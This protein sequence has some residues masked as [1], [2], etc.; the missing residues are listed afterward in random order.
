M[1]VDRSNGATEGRDSARGARILLS[2][3]R[4]SGK[5]RPSDPLGR[6]DSNKQTIS[7]TAHY[8]V[9]GAYDSMDPALLDAQL[10][11]AQSAG[12]TG[13]I[14][15]WW[16]QGKYEDHAIPVL[17]ESA[18]KKHFKISIYWEKAPGHGDAQIDGAVSDLV[19]LLTR[20]GKNE[21]FL[22]ADGIPVIF[23]YERVMKDVPEAS[24]P[25][26]FSKTKAKAGPFVLIADKYE[27]NYT[28]LFGGLHRYNISWAAPGR[29]PDQIREWAARY[30]SEGVKLA[31]KRSRISC[32]TVI[33]GYDDTKVNE[34][35]R[36]AD[37]QDGQVYQVLWEEA[38]KSKPDWVL[39]NSWNEWHEGT[40]IE[41]SVE[42]RDQFIK[43]TA[44][45]V[46]RFLGRRLPASS[47]PASQK[48]LEQITP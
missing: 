13:F 3:V 45:Y 1:P 34:P 30:D 35:G 21:A 14:A 29:T 24:W 41:P 46:P 27:E 20:Y 19:H 38:I 9:Q 4:L 43:L 33:P 31:R 48:V 17:L 39:I 15:S 2:L 44:E 42:Y 23:V 47:R 18:A 28:R 40:E 12:V 22:K 6:I 7:N 37:R 11:L 36:N 16:G 25:A 5:A 8:P 10:D 32:V 26:I